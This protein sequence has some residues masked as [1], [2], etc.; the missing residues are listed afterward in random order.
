MR[1]SFLVKRAEN[2]VGMQTTAMLVGRH[3]LLGVEKVMTENVSPRGTRVISSMEWYTDDVILVS[4][5]GA[6]FA[7]AARVAY[8]DKL[9]DGRYVTGLEF[10]A[11]EP[12]AIHAFG[13]VPQA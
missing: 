10:V 4:L 13:Q 11:D 2:R 8:C 9:N 1:T 12:L 6:H 5:P 7:S 3:G